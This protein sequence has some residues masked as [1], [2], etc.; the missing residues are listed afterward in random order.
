MEVG[1]LTVNISYT[2]LIL[3]LTQYGALNTIFKFKEFYNKLN[4]RE[5]SQLSFLKNSPW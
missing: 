1:S 4:L 5:I 2:L 3:I